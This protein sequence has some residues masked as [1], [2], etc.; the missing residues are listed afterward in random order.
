MKQFKEL[1]LLWGV[2][3]FFNA[4]TSSRDVVFEKIYSLIEQEN[5]FKAKEFYD[6]NRNDF[7][8]IHQNFIEAVLYNAFNQSEESENKIDFLIENKKSIPDSLII[9]LYA[10]KKDNSLKL[11]NYKEAKNV[12]SVI[13]NDYKEYLTEAQFKD[14]ENDLKLYTALENTPPQKVVIRKNS[15]IKTTKDMAGLTTLKVFIASD[16]LDFIFDTGA[17]LS[18]TSM[19]I[20]EHFKMQIITG[21]IDVGTATSQKVIAQLAVCKKLTFGHIDVYNAVFLVLPNEFLYF[22]KDGYQIFGILGFPII[23]ALKEIHISQDNKFIVPKKETTFTGQSN[24]AMD[25]LMPMI[26]ID[27]KNFRF[28]TG[29]D[30]T[31]LYQKYYL[32]NQ[33]EIEQKYQ[34]QKF[35]FAGAGGKEEYEGFII[36][37]TFKVSGKDITLK[38]VNL[39][40]NK[41]YHDESYYGNIGQDLIRQFDTMILN[42]D[43]MFIKFE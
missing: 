4:C 29:A 43:Q 40:K 3:C 23:Q 10:L 6:S 18:T 21:N 33:K 5:F 1:V 36:N 35:S 31:V 26:Y 39:L 24:F 38:N 20:A 22:P 27:G 37:P 32:E 25:G 7:L 11:F 15:I 16:S 8:Q 17:N 12:V 14:Y 41:I 9:K 13:L 2:L 34:L 19:S 42:F 30:F 28:D